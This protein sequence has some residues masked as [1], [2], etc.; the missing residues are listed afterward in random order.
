MVIK[1]PKDKISKID[2]INIQGGL[3]ATQVYNK[4]KPDYMINLAV[5]DMASG[6]NITYLKD[7]G[8]NS[9]YLF[10]FLQNNSKRCIQK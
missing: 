5:Y 8:V 2:I 4:Y 6:T 3:T 9:G 10:L 7:E 1:I